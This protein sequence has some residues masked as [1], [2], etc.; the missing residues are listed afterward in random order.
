MDGVMR[1]R[2]QKHPTHCLL[3]FDSISLSLPR[4]KFHATTSEN[5]LT[6]LQMIKRGV[7]IW[8]SN[9]TTGYIPKRNENPENLYAKVYSSVIHS[10]QKVEMNQCPSSNAG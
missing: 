3:Q 4:V 8:P 2:L 6:V 1:D 7:T 5:C 10:S 9:S